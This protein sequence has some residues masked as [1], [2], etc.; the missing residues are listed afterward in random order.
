VR[1]EE[2]SSPASSEPTQRWSRSNVALAVWLSISGLLIAVAFAS[3]TS[4]TSGEGEDDV[5][6]RYEF[7]IGSVIVYGVIV[8]LTWVAA[9]SFEHPREALG[10]RSFSLRWVWIALGLTFV[11]LVLSAALEPVLHAGEEQG[12]AP[13]RW[14]GDRAA[15]FAVNAIVVILVVPFAEELFFRGLGVRALGFLG[16]TAAVA[17]TAIVFALAHGLLS[18]LL[19]LGFFAAV[20][21]WV[22]YRSE[23]VWPGFLAHAAYNGVGILVAVYFALE[24]REA[25]AF[26]GLF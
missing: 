18:A 8:A 26:L 20:L 6:F 12:L 13:D 19:P 22:R 25:R 9:R 21:G 16:G 11:S 24:S 14:E 7:A 2:T 17:G 23:S 10:L 3:S 15:A 4:G 5:L 1:V